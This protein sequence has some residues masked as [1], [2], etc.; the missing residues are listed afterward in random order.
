MSYSLPIH[1]QVAYQ[2]NAKQPIQWEYSK[3]IPHFDI[4]LL[5]AIQL[6]FLTVICL[7]KLCAYEKI[8]ENVI[9]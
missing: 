4:T 6:L 1:K 5:S 8:K 3:L 2:C 7:K 9:A